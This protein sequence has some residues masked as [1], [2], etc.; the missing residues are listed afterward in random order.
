M[1]EEDAGEGCCETEELN[2][3][4]EY[5]VTKNTKHDEI[6]CKQGKSGE[7]NVLN[8]GGVKHF[9]NLV[10]KTICLS[11]YSTKLII[12]ELKCFIE[13]IN[14]H[15]V[16]FNRRRDRKRLVMQLQWS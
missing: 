9:L 11:P 13:V 6:G 2:T 5:T 3:V 14:Q 15:A 7:S 1:A 16:N 8:V 4:S 12:V 10:N